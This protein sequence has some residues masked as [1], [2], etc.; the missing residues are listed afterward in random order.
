[1]VVMVVLVLLMMLVV[2]V[3]GDGRNGSGNSCGDGRIH[4][5]FVY[6]TKLI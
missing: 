4:L 5:Q 2:A 3:I 1:M 6:R